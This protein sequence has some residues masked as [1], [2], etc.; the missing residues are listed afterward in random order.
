MKAR[1]GRLPTVLA[2]ARFLLAT[3]LFVRAA[4]P[5][6]WP[7][8]LVLLPVLDARGGTDLR[9]LGSRDCKS[10]CLISTVLRDVREQPRF[11]KS[12]GC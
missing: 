9:G 4:Q 8:P 5:S 2:G 1:P 6:V 11:C 12:G 7:A 10:W 3:D